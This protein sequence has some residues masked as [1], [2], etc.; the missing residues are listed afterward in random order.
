M[1]NSP[2]PTEAP[3]QTQN[4]VPVW[5]K[6]VTKWHGAVL[7]VNEISLELRPGITGLLGPNGA[8]KSTLLNLIGGQLRPD[9]GFVEIFGQ[10]AWHWRT[11]RQIGYCPD[12]DYF[13]PDW[14]GV[15]FLTRMAKLAGL[16]KAQVG[17]RVRELIKRFGLTGLENTPF[18]ICS[19]GMRQ[20]I[21]FAHALILDPPL[22]LL[23]EPFRGIDPIG[24][25]E[26]SH[27]LKELA[28]EGKTILV[29]SHELDEVDRLTSR[30]VIMRSG[31]ILAAGPLAKTRDRFMNSPVAFMLE[32]APEENARMLGRE[33]IGLEGVISLEYSEEKG[34]R[35]T[36]K[37]R[38]W[39]KVFV[40]LLKILEETKSEILGLEPLGEESRSVVQWFFGSEKG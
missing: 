26:V 23:D 11:K 4:Q 3:T 37:T 19:L 7:G 17:P 35:L 12:L 31:R 5:C 16:P 6:R 29:S 21:K 1:N 24:R 39:E 33:L 40:G 9:T 30:L 14:T 2:I 13:Y 8:G 28:A 34:N 25:F 36:I 15:E 27:F 22:V 38:D 20:R 32:I 18:K 10:D